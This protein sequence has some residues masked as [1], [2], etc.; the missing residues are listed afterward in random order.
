[1]TARIAPWIE[2]AVLAAIVLAILACGGEAVRAS[3]HGCLHAALGESVLR[4]GLVPEN[5]Y[6]AGTPL[7]Y[8]TLYPLLGAVIGR[9]GFGPLWAFALLDVLAAVLLAPALDALGRALGLSFGGRRAAFVAAVLGFNGLGWIGLVS[10]NGPWSGVP[11]VYALMPMTFA[12]EPFGWDARLQAFLPKFL[13]VSSYAIALPFALWALAVCARGTRDYVRVALALALALALNPLVGGFAGICAASW[14]VPDLLRG[15]GP[16]RVAW[17]LA[18]LASAALALPF[19]L[20]VLPRGPQAESLT[21]KVALGGH[22]ASNLVGPNLLLLLLGLAGLRRLGR[23]ARARFFAA[24]AVAAVLVLLGE[25]PQG[26]EYKMS[27]LSGLLWALPAGA[28]AAEAWAS[29]GARRWGPVLL[30]LACVPTTL[31]VPWAYLD[32]GAHAAELPLAARGGVL[33]PRDRAVQPLFEAEARADPRAVVLLAPSFP[34]ADAGAALVQGNG[35]APA[36]HHALFVDVPQIHN[37]RIPDLAERLRL[38]E[39]ACGGDVDALARA[40]AM[41]PSRPFLA[42]TDDAT[43]A[44]ADALA[45][46]GAALIARGERCALWSLP[47]SAR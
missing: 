22:P 40:R 28:F 14:I 2:G 18:F 10:A 29:G 24:A 3:Y 42:F 25:M 38:L 33:A 23:P 35:L 30:A 19:L 4:D 5:P 21:G 36:L 27:R 11:P 17:I 43:P 31:A 34:G 39:D 41:L 16:R 32:W 12:L 47:A 20:P 13:N 26:N 37:D 45:R 8:Y 9:I 7:R 1:M 6:H 44:L 15:N 46:A